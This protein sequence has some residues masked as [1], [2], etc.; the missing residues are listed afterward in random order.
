MVAGFV[1]T[2][3]CCV[4][5]LR[6]APPSVVHNLPRVCHSGRLSA[7]GESDDLVSLILNCGNKG[8]LFSE[9]IKYCNMGWLFCLSYLF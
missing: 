6:L 2:L 5:V 7:S 9:I 3:R 8:T 4:L 1:C